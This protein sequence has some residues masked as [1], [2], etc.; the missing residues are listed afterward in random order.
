MKKIKLNESHFAG[1]KPTQL[2]VGITMTPGT[3]HTPGTKKS[4]KIKEVNLQEKFA[5]VEKI[6]RHNWGNKVEGL[7]HLVW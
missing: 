2:E 1:K 4:H 5:V 3:R 6:A 7:Y